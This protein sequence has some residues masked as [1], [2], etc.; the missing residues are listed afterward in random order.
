MLFT[1]PVLS[2]K[3]V[4]DYRRL[5]QKLNEEKHYD[6]IIGTLFPVDVCLACYKYNHF[7]LYE[8]DSLI[9][10]PVYKEGIKKYLVL[11]LIQIEKKLYDRAELIIHLNNNKEFYCKNRYKKYSEKSVYTDIPYLIN[12][13]LNMNRKI[14]DENMQCT[15]DDTIL[16]VYA[17]LLSK[18]Y[19]S[20]G[21]L[22]EL[23]KEIS[24]Y[25]NIEC[26]FFSRGDCEDQLRKAETDTDGVIRRMGYVSQDVLGKYMDRADFLL[27]IGNRL[28]GEDYSLPSKV[29][30]YMA[31]GK[32]II[33]MN[34]VNDSAIKYLE[35]YGNAINVS[36]DISVEQAGRDVLTFI[37]NTRGKRIPFEKVAEKFRNIGIF[38]F[39]FAVN[40]DKRFKVNSRGFCPLTFYIYRCVKCLVV[41]INIITEIFVFIIQLINIFLHFIVFIFCDQV[42]Y[43]L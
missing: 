35:K 32:P 10:N 13:S 42:C 4:K 21:R 5:V 24:K 34:G 12:R 23:V 22:I 40:S 1:W 38:H 29:I 28:F 31:T 18:D 14:D 27:D 3:R 15:M 7:I 20:P 9:N 2:V 17:G 39:Y 41:G 30:E 33:H 11:R 37:K 25:I 36:G 8:L 43:N 19:R 6:A 26:L 16:V